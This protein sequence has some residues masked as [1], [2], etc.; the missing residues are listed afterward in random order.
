MNDAQNTSLA[1]SVAAGC[2][3]G[4]PRNTERM[5][6]TGNPRIDRNLVMHPVVA[7][8]QMVIIALALYGGLGRAM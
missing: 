1:P 7:A 2:S 6:T 5:A 3:H 8:L 4:P